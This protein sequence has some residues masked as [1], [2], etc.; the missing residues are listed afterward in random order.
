MNP[1]LMKTF[2]AVLRHSSFTR[3]AEEVHLAQSTVSDQIQTLESELSTPLFVRAKGALVAMPAAVALRPY[4]EEILKLGDEGRAAVAHAV[5]QEIQTLTIGS[6]ETIASNRL[7]PLLS[8]FRALNPK[9]DIKIKIGGTGELRRLLEHG[10]LDAAICFHNDGPSD[11]F[12]IRTL[13]SEPLALIQSTKHER[14]HYADLTALAAAEFVV[15]EV[16]CTYRRMFDG[17]FRQHGAEP[18]R[19]AAEVDSV[20]AIINFVAAGTWLGLA[21]RLAVEAATRR[22]EIQEVAWPGALP[23]VPLT[24]IWRRRRIQRPG[25]K[26][27]LDAATRQFAVLD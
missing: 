25:L 1:R 7:A 13:G 12:V 17:L 14:R 8:R 18:P 20:A 3:A 16:G 22:G 23:R 6:L 9:T 2:L 11:S 5:G 4:A 27:L 26:Q 15:T 24:M 10:D 21:P 19:P